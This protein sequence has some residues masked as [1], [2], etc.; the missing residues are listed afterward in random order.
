[1]LLVYVPR[2]TNRLGYTLN[3]LLKHLLHTDFSITT[4]EDYFLRHDDAV[5]LLF[6]EINILLLAEALKRMKH[7]R[8]TIGLGNISNSTNILSNE[9]SQRKICICSQIIK[10]IVE[11]FL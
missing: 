11:I 10:E 3:V 9:H 8:R 7:V 2:L 5:V 1:M 6:I 4:D